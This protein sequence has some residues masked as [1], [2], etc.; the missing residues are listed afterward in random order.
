MLAVFSAMRGL[1]F[2]MGWD[3][4]ENDIL[5]RLALARVMWQAGEEVKEDP[6]P[7]ILMGH[8]VTYQVKQA[9]WATINLYP[10]LSSMLLPNYFGFCMRRCKRD[11]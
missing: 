11:I 5:S 6:S 3:Y 4:F 1:V 2:L 7:L 9:W 8:Q 10:Y